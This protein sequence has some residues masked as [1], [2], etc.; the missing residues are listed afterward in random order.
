MN[1]TSDALAFLALKYDTYLL[2]DIG[3]S[4][5]QLQFDNKAISYWAHV[6]AKAN[7]KWKE[8][9]K[10]IQCK[11]ILFIELAVPVLICVGDEWIGWAT[12]YG[13][14]S[15]VWCSG[16]NSVIQRIII[17]YILWQYQRPEMYV[18]NRRE[19]IINRCLIAHTSP[20]WWVCWDI[21]KS[22]TDVNA[23]L[24]SG[25]GYNLSD[26]INKNIA[27]WYLLTK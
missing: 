5:V 9:N 23:T 3:A 17:G 26:A 25:L 4:S 24:R 19:W 22:N 27:I 20:A 11:E 8:G 21:L 14:V 10:L 16:G 15:G 2:F 12:F 7:F 6:K 18:L 13:L 1:V